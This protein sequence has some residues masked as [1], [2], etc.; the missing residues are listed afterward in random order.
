MTTFKGTLLGA[1]DNSA[2]GKKDKLK[3][4][5]ENGEDMYLTIPAGDS[6]AFKG[7]NGQNITLTAEARNFQGKTY[8]VSD[9]KKVVEITSGGR[10]I[11]PTS[12]FSSQGGGGQGS[13]TSKDASIIRQSSVK[14]GV[15]MA[16]H[17]AKIANRAVTL[18]DVAVHA[19]EIEEFV[20]SVGKTTPGKAS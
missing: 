15:E 8:Y 2:Q 11:A 19:L 16:V 14:A 20:L 12:P 6:N 9:S 4:K 1:F 5:L 18:N 7:L 13:P 3:L 10:G 17:N